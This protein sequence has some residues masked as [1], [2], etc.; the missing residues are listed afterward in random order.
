MQSEIRILFALIYAEVYRKNGSKISWRKLFGLFTDF[1][2]RTLF[3]VIFV[4]IVDRFDL[5]CRL[6]ITNN[7]TKSV[8]ILSLSCVCSVRCNICDLKWADTRYV[9]LWLCFVL[10]INFW[11]NKSICGDFGWFLQSFWTRRYHIF[12]NRIDGCRTICVW[13]FFIPVNLG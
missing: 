12:G 6:W 7:S 4:L 11:L 13:I 9:V 10:C 2:H 8:W 1:I 5:L 3:V